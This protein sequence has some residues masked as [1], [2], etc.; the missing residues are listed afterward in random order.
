MAFEE[1]AAAPAPAAAKKPAK[2]DQVPLVEAELGE[3][4]HTSVAL[5]AKCPSPVVR[6]LSPRGEGGGG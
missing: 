1:A 2:V 6:R 3:R 4:T 5:P